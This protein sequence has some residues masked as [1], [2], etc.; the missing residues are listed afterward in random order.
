MAESKIMLTFAL[1]NYDI[2]INLTVLVQKNIQEFT[3][4]TGFGISSDERM[5]VPGS[6]ALF[7][8]AMPLQNRKHVA[9]IVHALRAHDVK[10][11]IEEAF[12][13]TFETD[14]EQSLVTTLMPFAVV[15]DDV[16][17]AVSIGG[18]GTF[19]GTAEKIGRRQIPIIGIN[20]GRLGFLADVSPE[21][22]V[23]AMAHIFSGDYDISSRSLIEVAVEGELIDVYPFA[24]NEI[25]VLK[26][27]NSSLIEIETFVGNQILTNYLAD[28][29]IVSTP[30][31]STGYALSVG[32]PVLA[33]ESPTFCVAPV[34]PHSLTIRPVIL[35][36][37]SELTL[38]VKSRSGRFLIAID[39]RSQ[40]VA[41][42][43]T[44]RLRKADYVVNVVRMRDH[45]FFHTLRGKMMWGMD[46]RNN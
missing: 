16:D 34:A 43:T 31:G 14:D 12:A 15:P 42:G 22:I 41:D 30:T 44:I 1:Q 17:M 26:H 39:G 40:S 27:D 11:Y 10:I 36:D 25:A 38:R 29:L 45:N 20:T 8:K 21:Q 7:G 46:Q 3:M 33:P 24:L 18:D 19:L 5:T 4:N 6:I 2:I 13:S 32:G 37:M 35:S 23:D 28:G 9:R